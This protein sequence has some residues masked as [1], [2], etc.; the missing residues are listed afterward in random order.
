[1]HDVSRGVSGDRFGYQG[2]GATLRRSIAAPWVCG[3]AGRVEGG[4][5]PVNDLAL[6]AGDAVVQVG[7]A[8]VQVGDAVVQV[9]DAGAQVAG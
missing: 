2:D 1:M 3:T 4:I 9:G 8:V 7:D 5:C 6:R